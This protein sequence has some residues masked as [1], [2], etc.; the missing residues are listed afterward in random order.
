M[1]AI[2]PS[3]R[4]N[5]PTDGVNFKCR[6]IYITALNHR[7]KKNDFLRSLVDECNR[8]TLAPT[9][10]SFNP[11]TMRH[12]GVAKPVMFS[13]VLFATVEDAKEAHRAF[14]RMPEIFEAY[15]AEWWK[16]GPPFE[17]ARD[18]HELVNGA[19]L[20]ERR[21]IFVHR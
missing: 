6:R 4:I 10:I 9:H 3:M 17:P 5:K 1:T 15:V 20:R 12:H 2:C 8:R 11:G 21:D 7:L 16:G 18:M 14:H 19:Y 13:H